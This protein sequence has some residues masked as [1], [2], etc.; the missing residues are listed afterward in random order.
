MEI[1]VLQLAEKYNLPPDVVA[2]IYTMGIRNGRDYIDG[3]VAESDKIITGKKKGYDYDDYKNLQDVVTNIMSK[4]NKW[5]RVSSLAFIVSNMSDY[6]NS[7]KLSIQITMILINLIANNHVI[8]AKK[9]KLYLYRW[10]K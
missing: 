1:E 6:E 4:Y 7:R 2:S 5:F 8:R 10:K 9:G 3:L